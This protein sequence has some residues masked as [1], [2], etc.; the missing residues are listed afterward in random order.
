MIAG[1][2][3]PI[4]VLTHEFFPKKGG[5]ATFTEEM[6]RAAA[7]IG[8]PV[9]VWAP[10]GKT[11]HD[12]HFPFEVK[13]LQLKGSQ[14]I[15]CQLRLAREMVRC[16]R[17]VRASTLY[18]SDPGPVLAMCFLHFFKALKPQ[19]LILTFHGSEINKFAGNPGRKFIVNQLIKKADRISTPSEYT[20]GLLTGHFPSAGPKTFLTPGALRSHFK[21]EV[22]DRQRSSRRVH[23]LTVGRLHPR[24]GQAIVLEA[25]ADLPPAQRQQISF[26]VVGSGNKYGYERQ[27]RERASQLDFDV[28]FFGDVSN[29]ELEELYARANIFSMTSVN[30]RQSVEGFGLVYLEAAAHGLPIVAHNVGGVAEAVSHGNNGLLVDPDNRLDLTHAFSR[31]IENRKLRERMGKNGRKWARRNSWI[32]SAQ[33]L[34]DEWDI[35]IDP[36][37]ES[38]PRVERL[39]VG[40]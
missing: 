31:L 29:Q 33:L 20:H 40:A 26:W 14:D 4:L 19:R 8:H 17:R 7:S 28:T 9:E 24:K 35:T 11:A 18:L 39:P 6:A 32:Q 12:R 3:Q 5:I 25:L 30:F 37:Y 10:R 23:I 21:R 38:L 16:R 2:R 34:F 27:L 1:T 15:S 36:S 22:D 13:R